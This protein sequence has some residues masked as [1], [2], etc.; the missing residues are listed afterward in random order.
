RGF[1]ANTGAQ[2]FHYIYRGAGISGASSHS[3]R[4]GFITNLAAKGVGARILMQLSGHRSLSVL[5]R[6]IDTDP[7]TVRNAVEMI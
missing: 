1:T 5:Q 4:R 6:Y 7:K 3:G 2:V